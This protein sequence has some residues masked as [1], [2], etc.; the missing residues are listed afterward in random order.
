MSE[1]ILEKRILMNHE[2]NFSN[3]NN[4]QMKEYNIFN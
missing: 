2:I 4:T 3:P 1:N